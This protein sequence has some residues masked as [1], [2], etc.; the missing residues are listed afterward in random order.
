M[1]PS[2]SL[3]QR[4]FPVGA[5]AENR[6]AIL[7]A[8][9]R[10]Q[11]DDAAVLLSPELALSGYCPDD[12]L[13][14]SSFMDSV[15]RE[16]HL[17]VAEAPPLPILVGLPWREEGKL[18]DAAALIRG[19]KI[20]GVYKKVC[21]PNESVF[22]E[23]RYFSS[24][25]AP[26]LAF[27]SGGAKFAVQICAD[28][29]DDA[30]AARVAAGGAE[31]VLS[32][33][34]SPFYVGKHAARLRAAGRFARAAA[35]G[36]FY[37]NLVGGQDELIFDGASFCMDKNGDITRQL[38]AFAA[39]DGG[40]EINEIAPYPGDDEAA[41][42]ALVMGVRDYAAGAGFRG[43]VLGLSGGVDSALTAAAAADALGAENVLA[44]MM[45]SR[46][47]SAASL[48]DAAAI[49]EN[50][51]AELLTISIDP[52]MNSVYGALSPHL[53]PRE[54]DVTLENVQARLRGMLLMALSNNRGLLPLATGNKSE[55]ACGYAT[56]YGDM[57]GGFAPLK[58]V[59]KTRVWALAKYR[60]GKNRRGEIIPQ[61]V[62]AR[63]P[64]AELRDDQTDQQTL[65][66]YEDIDAAVAAHVE[67]GA[68]FAEW[69]RAAGREL[70]GR[71][72]DLLAAGEHKRRQGAPGPK[73][74]QRAFGRDWRMPVANRF[75][76]QL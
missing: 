71:F 55:I 29:W 64:S 2:V 62:I 8:A 39:Y 4:D 12:M 56:L 33:N 7:T 47:T 20:D 15:E 40:G 21:L 35:A 48:E 75:R 49:A 69:T 52:L 22:D 27:E 17:L 57:C 59:V 19:G 38:R 74:T 32:L 36:L 76:R 24:G 67:N 30:Q 44:V 68:P 65:P 46:H 26:P 37:C 16:F 10:A 54:G 25:D 3:A 14:D 13:H 45:P 42:S 6:R 63:A 41:Y 50:L 72:L 9:Q 31:Y 28:V 1:T 58:D 11:R 53:R 51:G 66:P 61:R 43:A 73:I 60:N 34:A 18:Y 5:L 23:R 70:A